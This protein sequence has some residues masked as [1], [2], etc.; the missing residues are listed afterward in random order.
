MTYEFYQFSA[1]IRIVIVIEI[2]LVICVGGRKEQ[3]TSS[4]DQISS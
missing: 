3:L 4:V 2:L 1:R